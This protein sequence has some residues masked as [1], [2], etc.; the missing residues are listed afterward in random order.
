MSDFDKTSSHGKRAKKQNGKVINPLII[1]LQRDL[2]RVRGCDFHSL[3]RDLYRLEKKTELMEDS[4]ELISFKGKIQSSLEEK[5]RRLLRK[6]RYNWNPDLP[7]TSR[8]D[9][10]IKTIRDH[11]VV[12]LAG[13]TGSGKTTQ[14]PKFCMAAG[15][16]IEGKIGCTQPRRIAALTVAERI[17][18]ELGEPVGQSVGYKIRFQDKD[19]ASSTI[20]IMTDGIL[21]AE[22]QRDAFLNE[23]DTL[24]IDEAH[25][26]S[27]NID[28]ILGY[29]RQ[30][31]KKR[32]DLKLVITSATI[33]TKK[34]SQAFDNAPVIEV[35]GRTY[36]V[37]VRY[38]KEDYSEEG[39]LAERAATAANRL[40]SRD[41]QGD[42]LI[43]MPTEQDI[44]E[45]CDILSGQQKGALIL[46]LYAR[47]SSSDQKKVFASSGN[48][49]IIVSTNVAETSLTIP[50]IKYVIDTG[51]A[52][53][54]Q[55]Y[56]STGTFALP[57]MAISRS[58]ADQR[59]GRCGR[60]E[61]GICVRLYTEE[62]FESRQ[63]FTPAEILRTNLAEVILRMLSLKL[64]DP[65]AFPFIDPPTSTGI[66]DGYKTL[67]ELAAVEKKGGGKNQSYTLTHLGRTMASMPIDPRLARVILEAS[68][69]RC[70]EDVLIIA[71]SLNVHDP[72]ERPQDKA[73]SADQAH[74]KFRH[75]ESDFMTRL[76][77]WRYFEKNYDTTKT[78]HLRKFCKENYIS[79][80]RMREWQDIFRQLKQQ[81]E[82]KGNKVRAYEGNEENY[83]PSIHRSILSGFLSHIA[84]RKE[85]VYYRAT[86]NRELMIFPG[87]GLFGGK[88]AGDWIVCGE[89]VKT[90]KLFGRIVAN[91]DPAWLEDLG[92]H[93]V[94]ESYHS[95]V[96]SQDKGTVIA[97]RQKRLFGFIIAEG[98][99]PYGPVNP[100]EAT[101]LMIRGAFLEGAI[102]DIE[103]FPFLEKNRSLIDS[104]MNMENKIRR[105]NLLV[106][107]E[108]LFLIYK[109]RL[110]NQVYDLGLLEKL[111]REKG[112]DYLII[113]EAE[114]LKEQADHNI[115]AQFP[116]TLSIGNVD[117]S[118][119]YNFE[120]GKDEDG[121]TLQIPLQEATKVQPT[122]LDWVI[123]GLHRDRITALIKGLPKKTRKQLTPVNATV[124]EI[125]K[126]MELQDD[127]RLTRALSEFIYKEWGINV[128][129]D[130]WDES[131]LPEHLKIR[132]AVTDER[133]QV[134]ESARDT[135]VLF[136]KHEA[137][138]D[139]RVLKNSRK[140]WERSGIKSWDFETLPE[141]IS[142]T[143][144]KGVL[145]RLFPALKDCGDDSA[146]IVLLED[147][148]E[149]ADIHHKGVALLLR[150]SFAKEVRSFKQELANEFPF[151]DGAAYLGGLKEL[152]R[153]IWNRVFLDI[154]SKPVRKEK[155]FQSLVKKTAPE[156]YQR[157]EI[158]YKQ[159][160]LIIQEFK[161]IRLFLSQ[162]QRKGRAMKYIESRR[163]ELEELI[164][165]NFIELYPSE[166]L[167]EL[168]RY[169]KLI[170][171]RT[172]KGI[173]D[174]VKD[175]E[176]EARFRRYWNRYE[177]IVL[178]LPEWISPERRC[179]VDALW[180]YFQ[181]YKIFL[182]AQEMKTKEKVSDERIEK[183][184]E[185][186]QV[187]L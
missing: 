96:W 163:Q 115:L 99:V 172:E 37:E 48:R 106:T 72:R 88:R 53:L 11:Q 52:R 182:F 150:L 102:R 85:K 23:Y 80:R 108:E 32:K 131:A 15:R 132:I 95:P 56:P 123:P 82:E 139:S 179:E 181:E 166:K 120:P 76:N 46:P 74:A 164:P 177:K 50:G 169:M 92:A 117:V 137:T 79:F 168:I 20:K 39:S 63:E 149:A 141:E 113:S 167:N 110:G 111:L 184:V 160:K 153:Q 114:L 78:G 16:G 40:I 5:Q 2:K 31:L 64:G 121:V 1:P 100:G 98:T 162:A 165:K 176:R 148:E 29:L 41:S 134:I 75:D 57:V 101:D 159:T 178:G 170:R 55:Y 97:V 129:L 128:P 59:K 105:R 83:L 109:Q 54:A 35:S 12:V 183:R 90:S 140:E 14:I 77:I 49:K 65:G 161:S 152:E 147:K 94:T 185:N 19:K 44:R 122:Q 143:A 61:N 62:D 28:F 173:L 175:E 84:L 157:A 186:L 145:F 9:E 33:D 125:I 91:I 67:L 17:A 118:V 73:G 104:I 27:L 25:E 138:I 154:A 187:M 47:L 68:K 26:R 42:L 146:A 87:S 158:L 86:R 116:D 126:N 43:F 135:E 18:Q 70:L 22:T 142:K 4:Q 127:Q 6:T 112:P 45:C 60:V 38:D 71:S 8:K 155:A 69:E 174:P 136:K 103:S 151:Q 58:S 171:I 7:I 107:D 93:L 144:K 89:I 124:D 66:S 130:D 30:L 36:P 51:M 13:E 156:L 180:W 3:R 119:E 24:I 133:G 34:F 10:I 81:L 21:L